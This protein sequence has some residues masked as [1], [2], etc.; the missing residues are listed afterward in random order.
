MSLQPKVALA[1]EFLAN[2]AK[3]PS[4]IQNK[5]LKWAIKFQAD[6]R[7]PGI[8]YENINAARDSNMKS[9]R[10]DQDWRGIV[11]KPANGDVYVLLYVAHHDEAYRWAENKKLAINPITGAMQIVFTEQIVVKETVSKSF[12]EPT[13][14]FSKLTDKEL[15][16]LGVP[17]DWITNV[18]E[19][20][21]DT[22]LDGIQPY[23]PIEAY[24]GLFLYLAGD[25]VTQI[26]MARETRVDQVIDTQDFSKALDSA[27]SQARFVVVDDEALEAIMNAPLAQWRVFLHPTQRKLANKNFNGPARVLGG[28]GTGKTVLAMHRAKWLAENKILDD[29]RVL[30]TTFTKNLALDIEQNLKSL[31]SSDTLKKIEVTNLDAWVHNFLRGRSYGNTIVYNRSGDAKLAWEMALAAKDQS[32]DLPDSFYESELEQVVLPQGI[33]T[34]DEYRLAKRVGRGGVLKR[35][36][37]DSIWP[38]FEEY[39][40]QLSIRKLK[41]VDDAYRDAAT[42]LREKPFGKYS[43]IVIDETQDFGPQAIRLLRAMIN[44][45]ENSLFFVGDG[46]QRIYSRNKAALSQCGVDIRGRARKLYINYRTTDEIRKLALS[47]LE[48]IEIDDLD[49]GIDEGVRYK[50]LSHG[51]APKVEEVASL[52]VA[53]AKAVSATQEWQNIDGIEKRSLC[54]VAPTKVIRDQ[55]SNYFKTKGFAVD[56][57]EATKADTT[58]VDSV[59]FSTMHRAKGLEFDRVIVISNK[60]VESDAKQSIDQRRLIYVA[61]TR[62]KREACLIV[63]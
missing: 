10:I 46:H 4:A 39:R 7:S 24:E 45:E 26:L 53:F 48:G 33:S 57:V 49:E 35:A 1:Q 58:S 19:L 50:S 41:E 16:S 34:L 17:E 31:C 52:E 44:T 42:L 8:N 22:S 9:V 11:F 23:L 15:L 60:L 56:T 47:M 59:F 21:D 25:S 27:E 61:L 13:R 43:A 6:P 62:A 5:I 14:P 55:A 38:V 36:V 40:H 54:I 18:S 28:A 3:L 37:R 12:S 2:L 63:C 51:P 32:L 20:P 29:E 30:F